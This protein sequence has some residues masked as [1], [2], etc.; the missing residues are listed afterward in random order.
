MI[1]LNT[2]LPS[3]TMT[4]LLEDEY[5]LFEINDRLDEDLMQDG[6]MNA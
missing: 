3:F 5:A 1:A 4:L 2:T 6:L